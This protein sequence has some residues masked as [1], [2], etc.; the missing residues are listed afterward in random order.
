MLPF[1]TTIRKLYYMPTSKVN[2]HIS[3][4]VASLIVAGF[5]DGEYL[6]NLI[7]AMFVFLAYETI[8]VGLKYIG[9]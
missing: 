8:Q 4:F 5:F 7:V 9:A 2:K 3:W 6:L 1:K